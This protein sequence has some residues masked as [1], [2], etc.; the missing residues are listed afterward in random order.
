LALN[1]LG[2]LAR[3]SGDFDRGRRLLDRSL[4][5]R[6]EVGDRRG[7][8]IT[9]GCLAVLGARSGDLAGGRA[10]AEQS[11]GWFAE[12]DDMIGLSA[13]ELCLANVALADDDRVGARAHLEAAAAV[14]GRR[15]GC[16]PCLP[17]SPPRTAKKRRRA[18]G[19]TGRSGISSCLAATPALPTA[20]R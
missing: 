4:A 15:A 20:V 17:R 11:R 6:Q 13:A 10:A 7:T 18:A 9:L 5:L 2:N 16:W 12:D 19:S 1:A 3:S 8:G 14:L